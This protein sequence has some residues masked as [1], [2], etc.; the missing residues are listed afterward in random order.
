MTSASMGSRGLPPRF[1]CAAASL[2]SA[3]LL[4]DTR[5]TV[6]LNACRISNL[7]WRVWYSSER[8]MHFAHSNAWLRI[9]IVGLAMSVNLPCFLPVA[10][11]GW[12]TLTDLRVGMIGRIHCR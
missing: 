2:T 8:S 4:T 10:R 11:H 3:P 6:A 7:R 5:R 1:I 9:P 12:C